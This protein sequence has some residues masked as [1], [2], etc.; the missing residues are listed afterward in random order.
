M[1]KVLGF[2]LMRKITQKN[3]YLNRGK[4]KRMR[5][6]VLK[7]ENMHWER[8]R[9]DLKLWNYRN[10]MFYTVIMIMGISSSQFFLF[11]VWKRI[12]KKE[13]ETDDDCS[14]LMT[15]KGET[16]LSEK[17]QG[18]LWR[19]LPQLSWRLFI[20][21]DQNAKKM[22]P[23]P[24]LSSGYAYFS[25]SIPLLTFFFKIG[26]YLYLYIRIHFLCLPM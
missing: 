14:E 1:N 19:K 3:E 11:C 22:S 23:R 2:L 17:W 21:L 4:K 18:F 5:I 15:E 8:S 7:C 6:L 16:W 24:V 26:F 25:V 12:E 20:Q 10:L 13:K 9:Y